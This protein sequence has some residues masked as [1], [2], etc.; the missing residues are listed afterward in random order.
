[1]AGLASE[2][3]WVY[4]KDYL[5]NRPSLE[6]LQGEKQYSKKQENTKDKCVESRLPHIHE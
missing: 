2:K 5:L 1:M 3:K 4:T 6:K